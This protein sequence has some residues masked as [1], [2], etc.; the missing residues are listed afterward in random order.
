MSHEVG[1]CST[2]E[3]IGMVDIWTM[4][5]YVEMHLNT[6][7]DIVYNNASCNI[8][9]MLSISNTFHFIYYYR[10]H[11]MPS[12]QSIFLLLCKLEMPDCFKHHVFAMIQYFR[13]LSLLIPRSI[14]FLLNKCTG[15]L[16]L[17]VVYNFWLLIKIAH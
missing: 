3:G 6:M 8:S 9:S 7:H 14:Y 11:A 2:I 16:F 1:K 10:C 13:S 17:A 15:S 5:A 12:I 4:L